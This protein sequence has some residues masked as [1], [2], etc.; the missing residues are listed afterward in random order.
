LHR[1]FTMRYVSVF[2]VLFLLLFF[3]FFPSLPYHCT[4][5]CLVCAMFCT[6]PLGC[7]VQIIKLIWVWYNM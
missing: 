4:S 6:I 7:H 2:F 1:V 5:L 3:F